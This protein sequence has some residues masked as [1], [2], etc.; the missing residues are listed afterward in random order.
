MDEGKEAAIRERA[1][2]IW[3][4]SGGAHGHDEEHWRQ[5]E[6]DYGGPAGDAVRRPEE[7]ETHRPATNPPKGRDAASGT[8]PHP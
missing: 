8:P 2:Q 3:Q 6:Q 1:F 7:G 5:A 4:Q